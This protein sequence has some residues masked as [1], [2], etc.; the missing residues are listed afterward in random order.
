MLKD[1]MAM[2]LA[3]GMPTMLEPRKLGRSFLYRKQAQQHPHLTL[4]IRRIPNKTKSKQYK[5]DLLSNGAIKIFTFV[6][7]PNASN[8]SQSYMKP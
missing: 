8:S 5:I 4:E 6:F 1:A 7:I 2:L 3:L